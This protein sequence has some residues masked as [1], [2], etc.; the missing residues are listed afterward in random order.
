MHKALEIQL[1]MQWSYMLKDKCL[2]R[3]SP[4]QAVHLFTQRSRLDVA[5]CTSSCEIVAFYSRIFFSYVSANVWET[6]ALS[7]PHKNK[8]GAV[9]TGDYCDKK[10]PRIENSGVLE[11]RS[12][13]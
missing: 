11:K 7:V 2:V 9:K 5:F 3:R 6:R 13:S 12:A 1:C 8:S 10:Y 4:T